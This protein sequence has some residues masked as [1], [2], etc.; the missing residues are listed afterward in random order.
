MSVLKWYKIDPIDL[1]LMR[2]AKPFSPGDGAWAKGQF[3]PLPITVFQA[4]RSATAWQDN[5]SGCQTRNLTFTGPFLL[6]TSLEGEMTLW[7]PTPQD[8]VCVMRRTISAG[9]SSEQAE[10]DFTEVA[11]EWE[12]TARFQPLDYKNPAW[13][14]LGLDSDFFSE[15]QLVPMVPPMRSEAHTEQN[16]NA[17]LYRHHQPDKTSEKDRTKAK[18]EIWDT[19]SGRPK[20]WIRADALIRYLNGEVLTDEACFSGD[21]WDTQVLPHIKVQLGTRQVEDGDGYFTEVAIRMRPNWQL[22]AAISAELSAKVVRLGGEG[23][24]ALLE[25]M[26]SPPPCWNELQAFR[27]PKDGCD[28]AYVLTPALAES[29]AGDECFGLIPD[30]WKPALRSCVGDRPLLGGGMS[31]FR[32]EVVTEGKKE[33]KQNVA[34]QPQRAFV[35]PG[36]IYRFKSEQV[37]A[38]LSDSS[39]LLPDEGGNWLTTLKSLNYGILLWGK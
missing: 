19:I 35:P 6:H 27:Q 36:T 11:V 14:H 39:R 23:H 15:E 34:F 32:K 7:L 20:P 24:R 31:V 13:K 22:V 38:D 25:P 30:V 33:L 16:R 10:E 29:T 3:P 12:R 28:T 26:S 4:L 21:P 8:L 9:D 37:S 17:C 18:S 1:L 2:E 5:S